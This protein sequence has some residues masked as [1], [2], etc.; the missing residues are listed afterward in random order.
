MIMLLSSFL[1]F[2]SCSNNDDEESMTID[3][4]TFVTQAA[5]GNM[6]EIQAG[7]M[8]AQNAQNTAVKA[9][10]QH[11]V[12]DHSQ[13]STELASIANS[14]QLSVP[15]ALTEKHQ[16]QLNALKPLTGSA[17][18]K[19]FMTLMVASHQEQVSL[20]EQASIGVNDDDLRAFA[21]NK[22]PVLREHLQG[23][24]QLNASVNP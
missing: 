18:D 19:A 7:A 9:Y 21:G 14:K 6:L 11:M 2:Q 10:G 16:A 1:S 20:F 17:F 22:L 23:A 24:Q 5:S 12:Q 13:A 3:R 4:Q 15:T 8:A